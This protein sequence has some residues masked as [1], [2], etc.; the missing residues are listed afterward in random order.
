MDSY[1]AYWNIYSA[2]LLIRLSIFSLLTDDDSSV[3]YLLKYGKN[4]DSIP[5][6]KYSMYIDS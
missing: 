4:I 2:I 3:F 6:I 5:E 1:R